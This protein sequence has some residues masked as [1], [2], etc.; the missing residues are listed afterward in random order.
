MASAVA[1]GGGKADR[2]PSN[3]CL[4]PPFRYAQNTFLEHHVALGLEPMM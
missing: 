1:V 4:C 3:D 2:A